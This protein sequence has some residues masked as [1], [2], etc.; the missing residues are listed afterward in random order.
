ME[1][2]KRHFTESQ[3]YRS[4]FNG[5]IIKNCNARTYKSIKRILDEYMVDYEAVKDLNYIHFITD[6]GL[7]DMEIWN[8]IKQE[9]Q[10][11]TGDI[12]YKDK[13]NKR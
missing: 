1:R 9:V 5:F 10:K 6:L 11:R 13:L 12:I 3:I 2:Y 4:S 8:E 7:H